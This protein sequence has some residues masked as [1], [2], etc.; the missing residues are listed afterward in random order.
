MVRRTLA[1]SLLVALAL[2]SSAGAGTT[3]IDDALANRS[4]CG[5]PGFGSGIHGCTIRLPRGR[6]E[7]TA[8]IVVGGATTLDA[9]PGVSILGDGAGMSSASGSQGQLGPTGIYYCGPGTRGALLRV[10]SAMK[11]HLANLTLAL[12]CAPY[13]SGDSFAGVGLVLQ[14][15]NQTSAPLQGAILENLWIDGPAT[16]TAR[17]TTGIWIRAM[18]SSND[19][20]DQV[21]V[22]GVHV[23]SIDH[24]FK[25]DSNQAV[26]IHG[27]NLNLAY[28]GSGAW[29]AAGQFNCDTCYFGLNGPDTNAAGV[30]LSDA[31][32]PGDVAAGQVSIH[33]SHFEPFRGYAVKA[34]K[35]SGYPFSLRDSTI[36]ITTQPTHP[37]IDIVTSATVILDGNI[38]TTGDTSLHSI[39]IRV[40][41][42]GPPVQVV[43]IGNHFRAVQVEWLITGTAKLTC[44]GDPTCM[45]A[46]TP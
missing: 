25:V 41:G 19:Q 15:E 35:A 44:I 24:A 23:G 45:S 29:I 37:I 13:P 2:A 3:P 27:Q 28:R 22:R 21:S 11:F 42:Q 20:V 9:R 38:F 39:Q 12:S 31:N 1:R 46:A 36:V 5:D 43:A 26:L 33:N 16:A 30:R 18:S 10:T 4:R 17:S 40:E 8:P 7:A 32:T 34:E 6:Y 14:G